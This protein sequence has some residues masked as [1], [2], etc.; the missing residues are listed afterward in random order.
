MSRSSTIVSEIVDLGNNYL[1][2]DYYDKAPKIC[3]MVVSRDEYLAL[4]ASIERNVDSLTVGDLHFAISS[5][6]SRVA[7]WR[8]R[9]DSIFIERTRFA[10]PKL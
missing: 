4:A 8:D 9:A 3:A 10:K 5:D 1:L 2:V 6:P 7:I